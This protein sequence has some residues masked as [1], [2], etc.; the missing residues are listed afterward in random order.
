MNDHDQ[1]ECLEPMPQN[2]TD[3][4]APNE[5][6]PPPPREQSTAMFSLFNVLSLLG[7]CCSIGIVLVTVYGFLKV[8][9]EPV[10]EFVGLFL[11]GEAIFFLA[12][13]I[14]TLGFR[15]CLSSGTKQYRAC[16]RGEKAS[17]T[18]GR[19]LFLYFLLVPIVLVL[20]RICS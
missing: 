1:N 11:L 5:P 6:E 16:Q 8:A 13:L 4:P 10:S 19:V 14:L 15:A 12:G 2:P 17:H 9:T 3:P 18:W 7:F 20:I